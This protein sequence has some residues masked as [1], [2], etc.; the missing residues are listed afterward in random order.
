MES[1]QLTKSK[2]IVLFCAFRSKTWKIMQRSFAVPILQHVKTPEA[3]SELLCSMA[4]G[5]STKLL[6]RYSNFNKNWV[7]V[8]DMLLEGLRSFL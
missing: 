2:L 4:M 6:Q 7:S 8:T 5:S 1:K 3:L